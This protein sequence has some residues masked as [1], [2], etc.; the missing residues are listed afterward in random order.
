MKR[1]GNSA[2]VEPESGIA[3]PKTNR[4]GCQKYPWDTMAVNASFKHATRNVNT[5][6]AAAGY[7]NVRYAPR[8]FAARK[9]PNGEMRIWRT[10]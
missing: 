9:M 2:V 5:A 7:A 3:M 6:Y 10:K 4:R 1:N 8:R